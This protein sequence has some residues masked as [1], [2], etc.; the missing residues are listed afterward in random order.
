M[1]R[2]SLNNWPP[3]NVYTLPGAADLVRC[4]RKLTG[5]GLVLLVL[6]DEEE[7]GALWTQRQEDALDHRRDEGE[8]QQEGPQITVAHD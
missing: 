6:V 8:A 7:P 1:R 3:L 5:L 4:P 2:A